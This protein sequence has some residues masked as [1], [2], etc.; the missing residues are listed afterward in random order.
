MVKSCFCANKASLKLRI[1]LLRS[2]EQ[3]DYEKRSSSWRSMLKKAL[4]NV[5]SHLGEARFH[6]NY[7]DVCFRVYES[8]HFQTT[9]VRFTLCSKKLLLIFVV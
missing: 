4:F 7:F 2:E 9:T 3:S 8:E 5:A 1:L 6:K